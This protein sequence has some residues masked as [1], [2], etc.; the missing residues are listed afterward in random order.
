MYLEISRR[1][2]KRYPALFVHPFGQTEGR[3]RNQA[4]KLGRSYK[5]LYWLPGQTR[6]HRLPFTRSS[7]GKDGANLTKYDGAV[8]N[9]CGN[10]HVWVNKGAGTHD[11]GLKSARR[12][13]NEMGPPAYGGCVSH[14]LPQREV[15]MPHAD[16]HSTFMLGIFF[17]GTF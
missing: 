1:D 12:I 9:R 5:N 8:T 15:T 2:V 7:E 14:R 3:E 17:S 16:L 10:A 6:E 13:I 11:P 4:K